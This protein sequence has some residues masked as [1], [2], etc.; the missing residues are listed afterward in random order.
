MKKIISFL[1]ILMLFSL[2]ISRDIAKLEYSKIPNGSSKLSLKQ[3]LNP[4]KEINGKTKLVQFGESHTADMGLPEL[5]TYTTL[6][7]LNP[8]KE[9]EFNMIVNESYIEKNIDIHPHQ[10]S[11]AESGYKIDS[12]FYNSNQAYPTKNINIA[13]ISILIWTLSS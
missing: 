11:D 8:Y 9:Y 2:C 6:Y 4:V 7:Q 1:V 10:G 5:P 3:N 12:D 13:K